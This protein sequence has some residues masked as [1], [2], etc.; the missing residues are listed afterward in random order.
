M[1]D[2]ASNGKVN[3]EHLILVKVGHNGVHEWKKG[4]RKKQPTKNFIR[5]SDSIR[6][7]DFYVI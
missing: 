1:V 6:W 7:V 5:L 4:K 3:S 2:Y